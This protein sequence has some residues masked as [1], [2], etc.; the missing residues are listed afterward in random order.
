L[1]VLTSFGDGAA[2]PIKKRKIGGKRKKSK[3]EEKR[4]GKEGEKEE[5][6]KG[7][8]CSSKCQVSGQNEGSN[9][10]WAA[11][12]KKGFKKGEVRFC[13]LCGDIYLP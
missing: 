1:T 3:K 7:K 6:E 10:T 5:K 13:G 12:L 9:G 8:I 4:R 11:A 2:I